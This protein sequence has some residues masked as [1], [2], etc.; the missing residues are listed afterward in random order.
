VHVLDNPAWSALTGPQRDLGRCDGVVARFDP[1]ISLFGA[2]AD[3]PG[4]GEWADMAR[5]IGPGGV[6]ITTGCTG[7]PPEGWGVVYEGDGVQMTGE[8]LPGA[9]GP[10]VKGA[11]EVV[12]LGPDDAD[13][14]LE[15]VALAR[16]GP[17]TPR[18]YEFGGYVGVRQEGRLVAM[19]GERLRPEGWAEISAVATHPDHRRQGLGELLVRTVAVGITARGEVPFLHAAA[20]NTGAVRLYGA[21]GFTLRRHCRFVAA[22]AP[23]ELPSDPAAPDVMSRGR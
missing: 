17:F 8:A 6:V 5:L 1:G 12:P 13:D 18:T 11:P 16:P 23:D 14:M 9:G 2:F 19:A 21:M 10:P 7:L 22:R 20:S 4:P 3:D 15:L